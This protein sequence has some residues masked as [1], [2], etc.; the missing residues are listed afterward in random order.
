MQVLKLARVGFIVLVSSPLCGQQSQ[1]EA[2]EAEE[3]VRQ[4]QA[5]I[6]ADTSGS[7]SH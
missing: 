5:M 2:A 3:E 1:Q 4:I 7:N 6:Q